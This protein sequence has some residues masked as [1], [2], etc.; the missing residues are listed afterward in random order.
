MKK[1]MK[2]SL[3]L[4]GLAF[5]MTA[6]AK[7]PAPPAPTP[8]AKLKAAEAAAKAAWAGKVDT[9]QLCRAQER[10]ATHVRDGLTAKGKT[11]PT[12]TTAPP[13]ADPGPFAFTPPEPPKQ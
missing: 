2:K 1:S 8:E 3:I 7:L 11:A 5:G 4:C 9:F 13:C 10:V 12:P 6:F